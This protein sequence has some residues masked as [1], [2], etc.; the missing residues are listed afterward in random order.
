MRETE[1]GGLEDDSSEGAN[2]GEEDDVAATEA[3][4]R[5]GRGEGADHGAQDEGSNNQALKGGVDTLCSTS[6][7]DSVNLREGLDPV[8]L[9]KQATQ[10][11]LVVAK[12]NECRHDDEGSLE[13]VEAMAILAEEGHSAGG[14]TS[15][16]LLLRARRIGRG[17]DAIAS[18]GILLG[19]HDL[20]ELVCSVSR[21]TCDVCRG[22]EQ[23][24]S[25]T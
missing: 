9:G 14:C 2:T 24:L 5:P 16:G 11:S 3:I 12:A 10:A 22:Q 4:A 17:A 8:L 18:L 23:L 20:C 6:E 15:V 19:R 25:M 7:I 13:D 1:G 21:L